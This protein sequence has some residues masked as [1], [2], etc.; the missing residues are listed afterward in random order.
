MA[1]PP[2]TRKRV[3]VPRR[4]PDGSAFAKC[5]G[6]GIS[7]A[8]ALMD[9]H[10]C[11]VKKDVKK[12]K[13]VDSKPSIN[14]NNNISEQPRSPFM[15]FMETYSETCKDR[16]LIEINRETVEKWKKMTSE[17]KLPYVI[18]ARKVDEAY[19]RVLHQEEI[20][21]SQEG[22]DEAES[23]NSY[24]HYNRYENSEDHDPEDEG[25]NNLSCKLHEDCLCV[26][27]AFHKNRNPWLS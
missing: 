22:D 4:A 18:K 12:F 14:E 10:E 27:V 13:G 9:M 25:W 26:E 20:K 15:F 19:S 8:V 7:V 17:E 21:L 3:R 24:K 23:A 2:R 11:N 16:A 1:N 5:D 6:C